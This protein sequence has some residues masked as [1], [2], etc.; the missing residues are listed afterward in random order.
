M[1]CA[2]QQPSVRPLTRPVPSRRTCRVQSPGAGASME[3]RV[4]RVQRSGPAGCT[5]SGRPVHD[6]RLLFEM[7]ILEGAQAGLSWSTILRKR[8]SYQAAF[9]G[10][11]PKKV[12]RFDAKKRAALMKDDEN[13][14]GPVEK[15][16]ALAAA[17][18]SA[19]GYRSFIDSI[20][21][22][23]RTADFQ[24]PIGRGE[25]RLRGFHGG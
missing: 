7:L 5:I 25:E 20:L 10:F 15:G 21:E 9:A 17:R 22:T 8:A 19:D 16:D 14:G 24:T 2:S 4:T 11:D 1:P 3:R 23:A 13:Y 6:D 12:T 18:D